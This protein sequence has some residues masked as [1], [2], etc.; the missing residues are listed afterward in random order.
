MV[1]LAVMAWHGALD[2]LGR[3]CTVSRLIWHQI[4]VERK[5]RGP[6]RKASNVRSTRTQDL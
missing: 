3:M 5:E 2:T 1:M 4:G 6:Y